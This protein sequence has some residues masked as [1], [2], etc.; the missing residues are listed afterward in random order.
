M[1]R[2][3]SCA[4]LLAVCVVAARGEVP[5]SIGYQ[6]R[7]QVA[8]SGATAAYS[9]DSSIAEASAANGVVEIAGQSPGTT[10]IVVVTQA[11]VQTLSVNVPQ[12]P[13]VLPPGFE[14]P[15][16]QAG[17]S[18]SYEFRYNSDPGE[19]TNALDFKRVQ[20]DSFT[21]LQMVNANLFS[22]GSAASTVG[23]PFLAYEIGRPQR[24]YTFLDQM[25]GNTP[26]TLDGYLVRGMHVR[27]GDWQFHGGF[28]SIATFQNLFLSTDREYVGGVSR[29]FKIDPGSAVLAN[30]YYFQNP[31]S[32][33]LF[34][35]NGAIGTV[36]YRYTV[37]DRARLL[38]EWGFGRGIAFAARGT[39]DD[40]KDHVNGNLRVTSQNFASLAVNSQRGTFADL[41]ATRKF[42]SRVYAGLDLSQSKFSLPQLQQ[43]TLTSNALVNLKLNHNFSLSGGSAYSV[44]TTRQPLSSRI[45]LLNLPA[46]IDFS[47]RHFGSGFQYQRAINFE[48]SGGN[49]YAANVRA[50]AGQ[51][52]ATAYFRHDVQ[53]P[54]LDAIFAQVPGLQDALLRAGITATTPDQL[55]DLLRNAALLETLGFTNLLTVDLAP[56]RNDEGATL[57]WASRGSSRRQLDLSFFNSNTEL[58]QGKLALA[59]ASISYGQR[60]S[61]NNHIVGSAAM[62]RT[63]NNGVKDTHPL[64]SLSLQHR[65]HSVP[66]LLLPGRH[67]SIEGHVFRDDESTAT[68]SSERAP[69]AGIEIRLDDD[70]ATR[71]DARGFYSFHHVPYGVHKVEARLSGDEPFFFT[72]DSP[73]A[74]DINRTVD[75]GINFAKGQ[76]FGFVLSDAEAGIAGVTAELRSNDLRSN[77]LRS[78]SHDL[79]SEAPARRAV[80]MAN[81][82]FVFPG[83]PAGDYIVATLAE[84]Y[85]AGYSLQA[86][87]AQ[88]VTVAPGRPASLGFSVKALRSISGKVLAYDQNTLATVPLAGVVVRLK[89]LGLETRTG[90]NG[91]YIFRALP[92]GTYTVSVEHQGKEFTRS[93]QVP[94]EP[95]A[96]ANIDLNAGTK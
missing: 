62:V 32:Q 40:E 66:G 2:L 86:L 63:V 23:F 31:D 85:P 49:D 3:R 83:V 37:K 73:A 84:S 11:G 19:I 27:E 90:E 10:N 81:G 69:L 51:V 26:L 20:G 89:E 7:I 6:K 41:N 43:N 52:H 18:G 12:P 59:T 45:A 64:F 96:I 24:D 55:A 88:P 14:P 47:S 56:A 16:A 34:A 95:A 94:A 77:D 44:F 87:A 4:L 58:L 71:T 74:T 22:A 46:A 68:W 79:G 54:T 5:L 72:T 29:A 8:V 25:V 30:F 36:A 53:T 92:T 33:Q 65:F 17:E 60:L 57:A 61:P 93:V 1:K 35:R 82:K 91:A 70:R 38:T 28:T 75:F 78:R 76:V 42:A 21:R 67:G 9:L 39:Y 48:G 13:P 15:R 50:S 80:T